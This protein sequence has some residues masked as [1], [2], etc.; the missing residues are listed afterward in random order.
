VLSVT[1][2]GFEEDLRQTITSAY[3]AVAQIS[4]NGAYYRSDIGKK[5]LRGRSGAPLRTVEQ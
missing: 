4:F 2:V 1:A 5:G 3:N